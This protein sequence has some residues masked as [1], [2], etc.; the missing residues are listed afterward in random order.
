MDDAVIEQTLGLCQLASRVYA[1]LL[2]VST[3]PTNQKILQ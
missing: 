2:E 3:H 1:L